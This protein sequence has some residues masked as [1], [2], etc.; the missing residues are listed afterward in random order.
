LRQKIRELSKHLAIYG[1]GDAGIH[2]VNF[3]LLPV[4]V[5][6]L[7][8]F[9][10][11]VL[12]LLASVEAVT[13]LF[14]RWGVDGSFM[15]FWYDCDDDHARQRLSSTLFF[16]LLAVNGALLILAAAASPFLSER[17]LGAAG[18]TLALQ[19]VL[20][21]TFAIGFTFIPFHVLRLEKRAREFT[22]L[23]FARSAGT[24]VLRIVLV[25]GFELSIMGIIV[26]DLVVTAI[27]LAVMLRWF[28]PLIRP[29]FSVSVLRSA[30]AFGLPRVPHGF[31]L[32]V[33]AVGD[34]FV[35]GRYRPLDDVGVYS[36]GVSFGLIPK[37]ARRLP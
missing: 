15:R 31:A 34:R 16:F 8:K 6:Y 26:A 3:L 21:N 25:V 37:I 4:Y 30:L 28:A 36:M 5:H 29:V 23:T 33:M 18:Y 12:A 32:Q 27:I 13:K 7:S 19:L 35:L 10:Y 20:L 14:F 11:G 9:D 2:A 24:L 1:L 17:L 22:A